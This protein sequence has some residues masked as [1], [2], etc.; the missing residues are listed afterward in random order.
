MADMPASPHRSG[1]SGGGPRDERGDTMKNAHPSDVDPEKRK[2]GHSLTRRQFLKLG[3]GIVILFSWQDLEAQVERRPPGA[4]QDT[5]TDVNAFLRIGADGRVTCFTGKV[6]LGQG[7]V[8]SLAQMLAEELDL[9]FERVDMVMGDTDLCPW[10]M[11][12]F[13]SRSI[14]YFGP[15]LREAAAEARAVL[16]ELAADH[17]KVSKD[18]LETWKGTV[19]DSKYKSRWIRYEDLLS[20]KKIERRLGKK[21]ALKPVSE[22]GVVGKS[23][24]R[25]DAAEK[26]TGRARF[27]GDILLPGML[28]ASILRPPAHGARLKKV[29]TSGAAETRDVRIVQEDDLIAVLHPHPDEAAKAL[30]RVK[31]EFELPEANVDD[32][33]IFDHL[34]RVAPPANTIAQEGSLEQGKGLASKLFEATYL[35]SYVAHAP[36]ETHT[37]TAKIE[38]DKAT[39]WASTQRPFGA[40]EEVAATLGFPTRNV[41]IIT[42]FVGGGFGGKSASRQAAEAAR[43]A[44]W[45]GRPVQVAWSRREEFFYDTFRPAAIVKIRS[46]VN[47]SHRMVYWDYDVYF[48]GERSAQPP[49]AI[50]HHRVLSHG[51]WQGGPRAHPFGTGPWRAPASNTNVFAIES[52]IDRMASELTLDPLEFRLRNLEDPRMRR[53]LETSAATFGWKPGA[54]PS[55]RG[56]GI[57]CGNYLGAYVATLAEVEVDKDSGRVTVKRVVCAQDLGLVIN[58]DGARMQ[59]EGCIMMGLGPALTEEIRFNGGDILDHNFDTYDLPRFSWLPK[60]ETVLIDAPELP[61]QGGGEPPIICMG[62]VIA[63]AVFDATGA[64]L[65][66]LPM[67]PARVKEAIEKNR[68]GKSVP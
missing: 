55:G 48:A 8:T 1:H 67:T 21:P 41:R 14:K 36:M 39:V 13:G 3:G 30:G 47:A 35:N 10:D 23:L 26:V 42:P 33:T 6:E 49:Y 15:A 65:V 34:L 25:T 62:A 19:T 52:H 51:S 29:D 38:G 4:A 40:Q 46:G 22:F 9:S 37:A 24:P 18:Q 50:P 5:P 58:P 53:V 31:A 60:I 16:I 11:G 7:I 64:R 45:A 54:H 43:L 56:H 57:A 61:S 28:Y 44:Q 68:K 32:R 2:T 17:F 20:G 59:M 63:N 66:Q 27:S 12:T